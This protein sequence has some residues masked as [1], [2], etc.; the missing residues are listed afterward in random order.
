MPR[1]YTTEERIAAFWE[2]VDKSGECWLWTGATSREHGVLVGED[3]KMVYAHRLSWELHNG[4]IPAGLCAL[5]DCPGGDNPRC[6]RP[7]HLWLGTKAQNAADRDKKCR[8][9]RG[10]RHGAYTKPECRGRGARN[11]R[12]RLTESDV[13]EIRRIAALFPPRK[14]PITAL[15]RR[16]GI[17]TSS[18]RYVVDGKTWPHVK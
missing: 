4:P 14:V 8:T 3:G 12:A 16:F 13:R 7:S 6:V 2:K 15:S 10:Q 11:G 18:V 5:H 1:K 9:A 17:C